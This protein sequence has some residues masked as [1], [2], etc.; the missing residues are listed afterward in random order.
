MA[1]ALLARGLTGD[2]GLRAALSGFRAGAIGQV[3]KSS[4]DAR[5]DQGR[6]GK[7][8]VKNGQHQQEEHDPGRVDESAGTAAGKERADRIE[9]ADRARWQAACPQAAQARS[10]GGVLNP[11]GHPL[12]KGNRDVVQQAGP[13]GIEQTLERIDRQHHEQQSDQ[14]GYAAAWQD[15]IV[16]Q[17]HVD[18][19]AQQQHVQSAAQQRDHDKRAAQ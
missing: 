3:G 9:I 11:R 14:R 12:I 2:D 5:A 10:E 1:E 15:R 4:H 13:E 17:H 19:A 18:R 16:D 6:D 7:P 8:D